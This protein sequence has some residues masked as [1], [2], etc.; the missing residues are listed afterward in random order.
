MAFLGQGNTRNFPAHCGSPPAAVSP[1]SFVLLS[2][3]RLHFFRGVCMVAGEPCSENSSLPSVDYISS[4]GSRV[5]CVLV[6]LCVYRFWLARLLTVPLFIYLCEELSMVFICGRSSLISGEE[7][8][9][10]RKGRYSAF[11]QCQICY[12]F[13][14][15]PK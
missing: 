3:L 4:V 8:L 13:M 12:V 7:A 11:S 2:T 1:P 6:A 5:C 15:F 10:E 14:S 9:S